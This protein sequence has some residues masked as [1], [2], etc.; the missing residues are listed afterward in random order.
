MKNPDGQTNKVGQN[1][2]DF[3][4]EDEEEFG[5]LFPDRI[6]LPKVKNH[7]FSNIK[8]IDTQIDEFMV[9]K[10]M[11]IDYLGWAAK[12]LLGIDLFP[13]QI[14][15]IQLMWKT[16]FPMLIGSRGG[17][18][19]FMLAVYVLLRAI[20]D[21]GCKIVIVGAGLRQARLVFN[22]IDTIWHESPM[23]QDIV[24]GGKKAGPKQGVD[25]CRFKIGQSLIQAIPLGDGSKI[26]GLRANVIIAD[27][28]ACVDKDT[29]IETNNGLERISDI[30]D[31]D[32]KVINRHGELESIERFVKTP[33]TDVY[34]I[35]TKYGYR[36]KCSNKHKVL[37]S[38][39]WKLGKDLQ[40]DDF[41]TVKNSYIFPDRPYDEFVTEDMAW[42]MGQLVSEGTV[43]SK[44]FVGIKTTDIETVDKIKN[45]FGYLNPKVYTR[46][47]FI[48]HRGWN[49]KQSYEI[50]IHNTKFRNKL[51][52]LGIFYVKADKKCVPSSILKS[53]RKIVVS[54]L[55]GLFEGDG[56]CFSWKDREKTRLGITYYTVS[57]L[58]A[59][60]VQ[61]LLLKLDI[62]IARR[63]RKSKISNRKQW[64]LRSNGKHAFELSELL[65]VEKWKTTIN[66]TKTH[67]PS[68]IHG[69][70]FDKS[71]NKW[72]V[73]ILH[74]GKVHYL[75][76]YEKKIDALDT[77]KKFLDKHDKCFQVQSVAK[78]NY[79][80]HLYDFHLPLTHSFY[81]NGFIQHNSIPEQIFDIVV[82]GFAATTKTPVAAA[83]RMSMI[84]KLKKLNIPQDII[85]KLY[86]DQADSN[87]IVYSG[88]ASYEF[89]HF[90]K[91]YKMWKE[92]ISS[93]DD[94]DKVS[95]IFGGYN[96][97]PK[98][99]S[100]KDYAV[101]RIPH[102]VLPD[103]LLDQKQLAHAKAFLPNNIYLMEYCGVFV[104]DS[105]GFFPR[106][107][108]EGCTVGPGRPISTPDGDVEFTPSMTGTHGVKYVMG[109]DP[110]AE[111]N[112]LTITILEIRS[113]HARVVYCWSIIKKEF[114]KRK[115]AGYIKD[116]DY[117]EYCCF[118]IRSIVKDF[119]VERI[120]MDSQGGGY[121]IAEMLRNKKL[122]NEEEDDFPIY[123]IIEEDIDKDTDGE[124]D[125]RHILHLVQQST[126]F[127]SEA[128]LYL[129]K[130]LETKRLLFPAFNTVK[131]QAA[132]VVEKRSSILF[133]TYEENVNNIEELKNELCTIKRQ[134]TQTGKEK[135][136]TPSVVDA[137]MADGK[138]KK[139]RLQKD[140]Y[141]GLLLSHKYFYENFLK[142][143]GKTIDYNDVAGNIKKVQVK[144]REKG[145]Y[146]GP[147]MSKM[148]NTDAYSSRLG[149]TKNG[150]RI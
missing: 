31:I 13:I 69:V 110:A 33:K 111:V 90:Y 45:K 91:R 150:D 1:V 7:I 3:I 85:K 51:F 132:I 133:D 20:L 47:A 74:C 139:G 35:I 40:S 54:F 106:T 65:N 68:E 46:K 5:F 73:A 128:N 67:F 112:N 122:L 135:F 120:E 39:G 41:L 117:Y 95:D 115:E 19:T 72:K 87:Q 140:R 49:C 93:N 63:T 18:K 59:Q 131:M 34:E 99:F 29:L 107:L 149:G 83:K 24:G 98:G 43:T 137:S 114:K 103:G 25:S 96:M 76:R 89:N 88:T 125:G 102:N 80:D 14:A 104:K 81:G 42:L 6:K 141:I 145:L 62:V 57:D 37:T 58:L 134:E 2:L 148:K 105:D 22:Y 123:E 138:G 12:V 142:S 27:E 70:T 55:S 17:S 94:M 56:S 71:R 30:V 124:K 77:A 61:T 4:S 116:M 38:D 101:V 126:N 129:H 10:M 75:G 92:I 86:K 36:F 9:S 23:L 26:R 53:S 136:D 50:R 32:T 28:F 109:I 44:N 108:V 16:T 119:A 118:K 100:S 21:Q 8:S 144:D 82:R 15:T 143:P 146:S 121:N 78:L 147:G 48:D 79:R 11:D 97:V 113:N 130:S 60:D 64:I 127:N 52:E 84:N 66:S